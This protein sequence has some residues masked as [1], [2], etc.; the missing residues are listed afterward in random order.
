MQDILALERAVDAPTLGMPKLKEG[1][2]LLN[3]P[4]EV[5][6]GEFGPSLMDACTEIAASESRAEAF[7]AKMEYSCI[8]RHDARSILRRRVETFDWAVL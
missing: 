6:D 1:V 8:N 4:V 3:L 7:M 2:H 5:E